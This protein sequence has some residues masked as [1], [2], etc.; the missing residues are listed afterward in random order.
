MIY[1]TLEIKDLTEKKKKKKITHARLELGNSGTPSEVL[2]TAP[3]CTH[4]R[5]VSGHHSHTFSS[6]SLN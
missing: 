1:V 5:M 3:Q 6:T 4:V 2:T